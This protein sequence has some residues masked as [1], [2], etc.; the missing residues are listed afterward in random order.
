[1]TN[2]RN[3]IVKGAKTFLND[4]CFLTRF[5]SSDDSY[6]PIFLRR[7]PLNIFLSINP[8]LRPQ[9]LVFI[10]DTKEFVLGDGKTE[11]K[12]LKRCRFMEVKDDANN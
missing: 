9:E 5:N 10:T 7:A 4:G 8:V 12:N 3:L 11:F 6:I 2:V 1:M